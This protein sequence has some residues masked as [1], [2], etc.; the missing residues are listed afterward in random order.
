[1][2]I[3]DGK[4]CSFIKNRINFVFFLMKVIVPFL[5]I[6]LRDVYFIKVRSPDLITT[7]DGQEELNLKVNIDGFLFIEAY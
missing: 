4:K 7:D 2:A 3:R 6:F 1:L 5:S